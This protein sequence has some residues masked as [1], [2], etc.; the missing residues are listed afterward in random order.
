MKSIPAF[1]LGL[2]TG[3]QFTASLAVAMLGFISAC[4]GG[5][6]SG[7]AAPATPAPTSSGSGSGSN[8][9][10]SSSD[11]DAATYVIV[12]KTDRRAP[13]AF[14]TAFAIGDRLLATNSHVTKGVLESARA[15][16]QQG[17]RVI[18]VS[19]FQ[20]ETGREIPLLEALVHPTYTNTRS[21]DVGLFVARDPLPTRLTLA[22][23]E[24]ASALRKG[25]SLQVNGFPGDVWDQIIGTSFQPGLTVPQASLF[26]G[27]VQALRNFDERVVVNPAST[28]TIDMFEHSADTSPGTSGSPMLRNGK[29]IGV[30][31]SGVVNVVVRPSKTNPGQLVVDREILATASFGIHVKHLHN[32]IAEYNTGVLEADKR[33]RLPPSDALVAAGGG[34]SAG[35]GAGSAF[36]GNVANTDNGNVAHQIQLSVDAAFNITGTSTWPANPSLGFGA[37]SFSLRGKSDASGKLEFT[38]N[39]PELVPGFRRG[40]YI[41]SLNPASGRITGQYYEVDESTNELFYFG[42]WTATR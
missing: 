7:A 18:G 11:L 5:G 22:S 17:E 29:V 19:A 26:S 6:D 37:R 13:I 15:M 20:S 9:P 30:H 36:T 33:F 34:Q 21:P 31:N 35:G 16:A 3:R 38:D 10:A 23:P 14:G 1:S 42:D 32:L 4:G 12:L 2:S 28:A 41:G 24:E 8:P 27:T 39:T 40:V 25:D